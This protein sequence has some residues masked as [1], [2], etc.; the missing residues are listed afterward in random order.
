MPEEKKEEKKL[1]LKDP[2]MQK[3][4]DGV[5]KSMKA[6]STMIIAAVESMGFKLDDK[7]KAKLETV[8]AMSFLMSAMSM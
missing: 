7:Q 1:E 2:E 5:D 8:Y 3:R 6:G 4:M